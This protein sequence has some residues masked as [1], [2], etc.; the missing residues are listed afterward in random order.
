MKKEYCDEQSL[1]RLPLSEQMAIEI[2]SQNQPVNMDLEKTNYE[3]KH[4][5]LNW[6]IKH[7]RK[8]RFP[9]SRFQTFDH[10][11][12]IHARMQQDYRRIKYNIKQIYS[13][14]I[15]PFSVHDKTVYLL[16]GKDNDGKWSDFGG[17]AEGQDRGRFEITACREF[18]EESVGCVCDIPTI[19]SKLQYTKNYVRLIGKTLNQSPY[20]MYFVRIPYKDSYRDQFHSTLSFVRFT[21]N[22]DMKYIEKSD[23]QW[24][25]FDTILASLENENNEETINYSLRKVFKKTFTTN[26][27]HIQDFLHHLN[28]NHANP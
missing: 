28:V 20:F 27:E 12:A 18:Y 3:D 22:F 14:G 7:D 10:T 8:R 4:Q 9:R 16:L 25:S 23:I 19:L 24:I 11:K 5:A 1:N 26:L 2:K 15:L 17:R 13:A 6:R 21:K